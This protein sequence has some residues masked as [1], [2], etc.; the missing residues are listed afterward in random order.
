[1]KMNDFSLSFSLAHVHEYKLNIIFLCMLN[2][3]DAMVS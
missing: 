2:E 3:F 1:M